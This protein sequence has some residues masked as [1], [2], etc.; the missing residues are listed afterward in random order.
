MSERAI[1]I[2]AAPYMCKVRCFECREI[3]EVHP[4]SDSLGPDSHLCN[5][6]KYVKQVQERNL[7]TTEQIITAGVRRAGYSDGF[8]DGSICTA[9]LTAVVLIG[10]YFL[11]LKLWP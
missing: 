6:C 7:A 4:E 5:V 1:Q 10:T 3:F 2:N 8:A 11:F 9:F